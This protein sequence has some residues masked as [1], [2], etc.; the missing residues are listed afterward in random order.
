MVPANYRVAHTA[1]M[2]LNTWRLHRNLSL[3]R[4]VKKVET[5]VWFCVIIAVVCLVW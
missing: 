2:E 4:H 3:F 1:G 5:S